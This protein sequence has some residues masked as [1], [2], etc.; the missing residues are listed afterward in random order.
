M[1]YLPLWDLSINIL[2]IAETDPFRLLVG[3][4]TVLIRLYVANKASS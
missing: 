2:S 3:N 4:C 1:V